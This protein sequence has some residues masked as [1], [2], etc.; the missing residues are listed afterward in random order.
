MELILEGGHYAEITA[1]AAQAPK[2]VLV[3]RRA[4]RQDATV[5]SDHIS[6]DE[7]VDRKAVLAGQPSKAATEGE[8]GDARI[9]DSASSRG[10]PE[11][12]GLMVELDPLHAGL[13]PGR[14]SSRID[15]NALHGREVDD[16]APVA[17]G[18]AR[19]VVTS[20]A[21]RDLQALIPA[22][23]HGA[24]HVG[25]AGTAGNQGWPSVEHPVP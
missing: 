8:S 11:G 1:A 9:G 6:R 25:S 4:G 15:T 14:T 3:L 19:V 18:K 16:E 12:L 20:A 10:E 22:E 21:H 13:G 23:V 2:E 24:H 17:D 7:I 5:G